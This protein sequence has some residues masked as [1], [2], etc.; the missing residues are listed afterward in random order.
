MMIL[1][2]VLVV[3]AMVRMIRMIGDDATPI[4]I[5]AMKVVNDGEW[6]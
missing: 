1:D 4:A 5:F 2:V 3:C 6:Y